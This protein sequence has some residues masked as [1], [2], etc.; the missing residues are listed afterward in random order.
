MRRHIL[1]GDCLDLDFPANE[2]MSQGHVF[3]LVVGV[4]TEILCQRNC[5]LVVVKKFELVPEFLH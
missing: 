3:G 1:D 2:M 4:I 5:T